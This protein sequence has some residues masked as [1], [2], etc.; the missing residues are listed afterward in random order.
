MSSINSIQDGRTAPVDKN[1][2]LDCLVQQPVENTPSEVRT[3]TSTS[4]L[5]YTEK[6]KGPYN[7]LKDIL[8]YIKIGQTVSEV[9]SAMQVYVGR[10]ISYFQV[11]ACPN[12][13]DDSVDPP[14]T[15]GGVWRVVGVQIYE[16]TAGDHA[17]IRIEYE[18]V[19]NK[20]TDSS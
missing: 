12:R 9:H 17:F 3:G 19:Y 8:S 14:V 20:T 16:H 4:T 2:V 10:L 7:K 15:Y 13:I 1:G 11:P 6:F 5:K 18:G